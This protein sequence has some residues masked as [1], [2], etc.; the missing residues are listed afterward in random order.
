MVK[1]GDQNT[2]GVTNKAKSAYLG[3]TGPVIDDLQPPELLELLR[4]SRDDLHVPPL[5][6]KQQHLQIAPLP[7]N[8]PQR[9]DP[10]PH[11][12]PKLQ[13][14][15]RLHP[16]RRRDDQR[17]LRR[18]REALQAEGQRLGR[19]RDLRGDEHGRGDRP[20]A[21]RLHAEVVQV[22][23]RERALARADAHVDEER[24]DVGGH[25][26]RRLL[27]RADDGALL[28]DVD[29][30]EARGDRPPALLR[31][32]RVEDCAEDVR[33]RVDGE[34]PEVVRGAQRERVRDAFD[35]DE[36]LERPVAVGH[37]GAAHVEH[38]QVRDGQL[39]VL[40][41]LHHARLDRAALNLE[42]PQFGEVVDEGEVCVVYEH[43]RECEGGQVRKL[44]DLREHRFV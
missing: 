10:L 29:V 14:P 26:G 13:Q 42:R 21:R 12:D 18:G 44:I 22:R 33:G 16:P 11:P 24:V 37:P 35:G 15:Q 39:F 4:D 41:R 6:I 7:P 34:A 2:E 40:H 36:V 23:V 38:R 19:D 8:A 25:G 5:A 27:A 9:A 3:R 20:Q 17:G 31:F 30:L 1:R 28:H 32:E 43:V